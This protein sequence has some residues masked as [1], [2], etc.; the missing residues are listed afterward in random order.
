MGIEEGEET[1]VK[2]PENIANKI[3]K[4]NIPEGKERHTHKDTSTQNT[5]D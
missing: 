5:I 3:T 2:G 1:P 4:E